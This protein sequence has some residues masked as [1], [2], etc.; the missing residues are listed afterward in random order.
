MA[1]LRHAGLCQVIATDT[2]TQPIASKAPPRPSGSASGRAQCRG[3]AWPA[4]KASEGRRR[5]GASEPVRP[6]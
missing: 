1:F 4:A 2:D 3:R 6:E 5:G